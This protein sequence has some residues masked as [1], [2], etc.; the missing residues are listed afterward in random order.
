MLDVSDAQR[1]VIVGQGLHHGFPAPGRGAFGFKLL[2]TSHQASAHAAASYAAIVSAFSGFSGSWSASKY[3]SHSGC[4][5]L[6]SSA[7]TDAI[8]IRQIGPPGVSNGPSQS[9]FFRLNSAS[10]S[11]CFAF[12]SSP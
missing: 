11:A 5:G 4:F 8:L 7:S 10:A 9:G 1:Q 6:P 3:A 12:T 2:K